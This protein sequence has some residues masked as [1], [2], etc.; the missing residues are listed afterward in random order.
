MQRKHKPHIYPSTQSCWQ[1]FMI[2]YAS[3]LIISNLSFLIITIK[4]IDGTLQCIRTRI[5]NIG[6]C[7]T[8]TAALEN[9]WYQLIPNVSL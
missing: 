9:L 1:N 4:Q 5:K 7:D 6:L 8:S 3:L 2:H